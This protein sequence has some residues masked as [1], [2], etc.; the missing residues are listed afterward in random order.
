MTIFKKIKVLT[1]V[2]IVVSSFLQSTS[3]AQTMV[4]GIGQ[5]VDSRS[6]FNEAA[7]IIEG[8]LPMVRS[9]AQPNLI[10]L[11]SECVR[12]SEDFT[13]ESAVSINPINEA[14]ELVYT[15]NRSATFFKE[16]IPEAAMPQYERLKQI[17]D[18]IGKIH[19]FS[20]K[21]RPQM[22]HANMVT[23]QRLINDLMST[24]QQNDLRNELAKVLILVADAEI[25]SSQGDVPSAWKK[26]DLVY[27]Q[28]SIILPDLLRR[29]ESPNAFGRAK[30][31]YAINVA[32]GNLSEKWRE[33][34]APVKQ[35][36]VIAEP[37]A[38]ADSLIVPMYL[39]PLQQPKPQIKKLQNLKLK[40]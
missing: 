8:I 10:D 31:I 22:I 34:D 11:K 1:W 15:F 16:V 5:M 39:Q 9:W 36:P 7:K 20:D 3:Y 30:Q 23:M 28:L 35:K 17:M 38:A 4:T 12:I 37:P 29:S 26:A 32:Y 2:L 33:D 40:D 25:V 19:G 27:Y 24:V 14:F 13:R 21:P 18:S 6:R